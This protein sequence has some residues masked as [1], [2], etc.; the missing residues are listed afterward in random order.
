[1]KITD[2]LLGE[3]GVFY[4]QFD[5]MEQMLDASPLALIQAQG[6]LLAGGLV[7]HALI[8][9]EILFPAI[10]AQMGGS[11]G[12]IPVMRAEHAEIEGSLE[13]LQQLHELTQAHD[14]IEGAFARLPDT[15]DTQAAR[16]L[17]RHTIQVAREHFA[18]EEQ[19]LFPMAIE[20]LNDSTLRE[21]G[22]Q[23]AA[24]RGVMVRD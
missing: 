19:I 24:R 12:P 18:K 11:F 21:L 8:E 20:M 4:A 5:Q 15:R 22:Q 6:A 16:E 23:W 14:D 7:P 3:H 13:R 9:N 10:E 2:A 1:M 17:V